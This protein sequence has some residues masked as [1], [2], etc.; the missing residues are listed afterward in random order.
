MRRKTLFNCTLLIPA[1]LLLTGCSKIKEMGDRVCYPSRCINV[2]VVKSRQERQLGLMFRNS[3]DEASGMLFI[4]PSAR[5]HKFWMK[6]TNIPL[7][8]IWMDPS[9]RVVYIERDVQPCLQDPC[10]F[11][12]SED[13]SLY[14][15]EINAGHSKRFKIKIGDVADF[16]LSNHEN[17]L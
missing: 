14:V 17:K 15:L 7:D 5:V 11:Y 6:N 1:L 4:F 3:L 16:H 12:F 2:E 9:R 8:M 13:K 10:P